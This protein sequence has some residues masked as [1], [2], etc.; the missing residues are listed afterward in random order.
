MAKLN[1]TFGMRTSGK[2]SLKRLQNCE[3]EMHFRLAVQNP[4]S[5]DHA[6]F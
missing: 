6:T 3:Y 4:L 1:H 5:Y 2:W